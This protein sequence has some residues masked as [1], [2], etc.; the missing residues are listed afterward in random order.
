MVK[1]SV[2]FIFRCINNSDSQHLSDFRDEV[3]IT[4]DPRPQSWI[5]P[6]DPRAKHPAVDA[7]VTGISAV[8]QIRPANPYCISPAMTIS[9]A[10]NTHLHSATCH[11]THHIVNMCFRLTTQASW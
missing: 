5:A 11:H 6:T 2:G 9:T 1:T 4:S 3:W 8:L 7:I 10:A